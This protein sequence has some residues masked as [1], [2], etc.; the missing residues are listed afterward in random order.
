MAHQAKPE[1]LYLFVTAFFVS[2]IAPQQ[3]CCM[4][5]Y[6]PICGHYFP[7]IKY[8]YHEK[9]LINNRVAVPDPVHCG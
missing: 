8:D 2:D 9:K 3:L 1:F 7:I 6:A 5:R 4:I